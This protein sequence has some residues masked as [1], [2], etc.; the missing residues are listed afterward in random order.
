MRGNW[1]WALALLKLTL[2]R[3]SAA[4]VTSASCSIPITN[5]KSDEHYFNVMQYVC[6][7]SLGICT[8]T[9]SQ[10]VL[11]GHIATWERWRILPTLPGSGASNG[12]TL[13]VEAVLSL[14]FRAAEP[15]LMKQG[16]VKPKPVGGRKGP[17]RVR[18]SGQWIA[19]CW[20]R[21]RC[22]PTY[23]AMRECGITFS[24]LCSEKNQK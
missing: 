5:W 23:S 4:Y 6:L 24:S 3:C 20:A 9:I 19:K 17:G 22:W 2:R 21:A 15:T 8:Q 18:A 12:K 10:W 14:L 1:Q 11:V 7:R 13:Q 16:I